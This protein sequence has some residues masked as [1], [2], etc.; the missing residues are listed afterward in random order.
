MNKSCNSFN[1][2]TISATSFPLTLFPFQIFFE[3]K[4]ISQFSS[5]NFNFSS[6]FSILSLEIFS[7]IFLIL[8]MYFE[9]PN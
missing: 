5:I 7:A 3:R 6:L 8:Y 4:N 2:P 9:I 1:S